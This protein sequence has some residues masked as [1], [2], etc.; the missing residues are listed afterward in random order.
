MCYISS[1]TRASTSLPSSI[2]HEVARMMITPDLEDVVPSRK[3]KRTLARKPTKQTVKKEE[4]EEPNQDKTRPG[5]NH[6]RSLPPKKRIGR[7][8]VATILKIETEESE[9]KPPKNWAE[10]YSVMKE[11]RTNG[12]SQN[13]AVDSMGCERIAD[14]NASPRERRFH[15]LISLMLSSQTKDTINAATMNRLYNELPPYQQGEKHGLTVE[16]VLAVDANLL[17]Q[18]IWAVGFHNNK[19][20]YIKATAEILRDQWN[21]DIPD[22]FQGLVS[23]PGVGPKMAYLCLSSAWGRT[24]GIGV[25]VHVHR[26]T[27]L[28]G[29]HKTKTPEESRVALQ[30][31]LPKEL[32]HEINWL[33]VGLGQT[34]CLP[35]GRKCGQCDLAKKGLCISANVKPLPK[36]KKLKNRSANITFG[37]EHHHQYTDLN[38]ELKIEANQDSPS[39]TI[40]IKKE[41]DL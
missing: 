25:D 38:Y 37:E 17:N 40:K 29:W 28:W 32:W 1:R 4:E 12:V 19:T 20:K 35:V 27:N 18:L 36:N 9:V 39:N 23:L 24:E 7:K 6:S 15:T 41:D 31:W 21:S 14:A 11:M 22:T 2:S 16:N 5:L 3:R 34:T 33:L 26:I 8:S 10:T 13:A 30:A